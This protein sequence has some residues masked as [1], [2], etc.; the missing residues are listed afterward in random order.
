MFNNL[1]ALAKL[2]GRT[3]LH[4]QFI[5]SDPWVTK[6]RK[7]PLWQLEKDDAAFVVNVDTTQEH[8][9]TTNRLQ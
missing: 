1:L 2:V 6:L 7:Q 4:V 5:Y 3:S 9:R 8:A